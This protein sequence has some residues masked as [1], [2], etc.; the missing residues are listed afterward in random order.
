MRGW[1]ARESKHLVRKKHGEHAR[2]DALRRR[3][4]MERGGQPKGGLETRKRW[5]KK[6]NAQC[7]IHFFKQW[8]EELQPIVLAYAMHKG[9]ANVCLD[10]FRPF[11]ANLESSVS[12]QVRSN[13]KTCQ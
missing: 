8:K 4:K 1:K 6:R 10:L 11:Q 13:M 2:H 3:R 7:Y 9:K 5:T 12:A